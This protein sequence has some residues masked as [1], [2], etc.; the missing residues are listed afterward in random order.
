VPRSPGSERQHRCA[1]DESAT[2]DW[3]TQS[4]SLIIMPHAAIL[5]RER[6][7][8]PPPPAGGPDQQSRR[9]RGAAPIIFSSVYPIRPILRIGDKAAR[10]NRAYLRRKVAGTGLRRNL[11]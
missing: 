1:E 11:Q 8:P 5:P 6:A 2:G 7:R 9:W 4:L 3:G 10:L